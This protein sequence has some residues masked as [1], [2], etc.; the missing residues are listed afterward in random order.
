MTIK[1]ETMRDTDMR[2]DGNVLGG[3]FSELFVEDMTRSR[4]T[5]AA[6]GYA[7]P[8]AELHVY[9]QAPGMVARCP[10][11]GSVQLRVVADHRRWWLD[12]SGTRCI[13]VTLAATT[14]SAGEVIQEP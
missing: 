13:E 7:G 3:V 5:C 9:P 4:T 8:L 14:P 12:F 10:A 11:C 2:L 6:C 1:D